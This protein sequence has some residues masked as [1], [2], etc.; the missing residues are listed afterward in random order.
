M[1]YVLY[2]AGGHAKVVLDIIHSQGNR[3]IG[4]LDDHLQQTKWNNINVLGTKDCIPGVIK[5][6]PQALFMVTIGNNQTRNKIV[7][8][9]K[10]NGCRFGAAIHSSAIIGSN[11]RIGIGTV[12]M[13]NVVINAGTF[14]GDHVIINT[15]ATVDHDCS[16]SDYVHICPGVHMAGGVQIGWGTQIGTGASL[17]P[18]IR[19]GSNTIVG[20]ASCVIRDVPDHVVAVGNPSR[21]IRDE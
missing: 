1:E 20:A 15:A 5:E 3:V 9:L 12:I 4:V 18:Q 2:G 21:V 14:I 19:V 10:E 11:V 16:L 13:P 7:S 17:I 8:N 6:F